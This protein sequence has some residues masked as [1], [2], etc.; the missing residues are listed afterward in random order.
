MEVTTVIF[1]SGLEV[2]GENTTKDDNADYLL[3][4]RPLVVDH[5]SFVVQQGK[6]VAVQSMPYFRPI[7]ASSAQTILRVEKSDTLIITSASK[8]FHDAYI[9]MTTGLVMPAA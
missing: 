1:K 4:N 6:G 8:Q 2:L 3:L 9:Q 5:H 7:A